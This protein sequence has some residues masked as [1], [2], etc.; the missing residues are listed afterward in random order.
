[1]SILYVGDVL[2]SE[3]AQLGT[4]LRLGHSV[5]FTV[6]THVLAGTHRRLD[7]AIPFALGD[8]YQFIVIVLDDFDLTKTL[9]QIIDQIVGYL[10]FEPTDPALK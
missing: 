1:M 2:A 4:K 8:L 7:G 9:A 3:R 6:D 10:T 5:L